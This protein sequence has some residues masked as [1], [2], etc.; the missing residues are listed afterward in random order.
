MA[1]PI[2]IRIRGSDAESDAPTV[3]DFIEQIRDL[4]ALLHDVEKAIDPT[5]K[6]AIEW[7][8]TKA[9]TNSPIAI[10]ATPFSRDHAAYIEPRAR[11]VLRHTASGLNQL[12]VAPER[13][14]YFTEAM[15]GRAKRVSQRVT[16][17]LALT[18]IE[19]GYGEPDFVLTPQTASL[20]VS[21]AERALTPP[22]ARAYREAGSMEGYIGGVSHDGH[23]R[24]V[25]MLR[26]RVTGDDVKCFLKGE[27]YRTV[28]ER[29]I[30]EVLDGRRVRVRGT[31]FNKAPRKIDHIE[32]TALEFVRARDELPSLADISDPNFTG[33]LTSEDYLEALRDGRLH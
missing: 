29:Q 7:R 24:A 32:A 4:V 10:E 17:G 9:S 28:R 33:G 6:G 15:V 14:T 18:E 22:K 1:D 3:E 8:I 30:A 13:P 27:A 12:K 31:I 5:G 21:N 23:G 16:N 11:E 26:S 25:M 2:K 19:F 20:M